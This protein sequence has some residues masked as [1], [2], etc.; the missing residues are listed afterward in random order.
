MAYISYKAHWILI[1]ISVGLLPDI[2][3]FL[4]AHAQ[5]GYGL[6]LATGHAVLSCAKGIVSHTVELTNCFKAVIWSLT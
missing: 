6:G 4:S 2:L 1:G 3:L 5:V